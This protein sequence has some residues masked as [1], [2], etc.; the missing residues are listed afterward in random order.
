MFDFD[1]YLGRLGQ[2]RGEFPASDN[3]LGSE[4][5]KDCDTGL[6]FEPSPTTAAGPD[7]EIETR[8]SDHENCPGTPRI[9]GAQSQR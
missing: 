1:V 4:Q 8:D 6:G 3:R 9:V 2:A 7:S 5:H